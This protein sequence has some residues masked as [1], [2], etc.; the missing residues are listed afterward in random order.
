ML[1]NAGGVRQCSLWSMWKKTRSG[2]YT[3]ISYQDSDC[4]SHDKKSKVV[5]FFGGGSQSGY[6]GRGVGASPRPDRRHL[7]LPR[8]QCSPD[9]T[10]APSRWVP[11]QKKKTLNLLPI[12]LKW[13]KLGQGL[14]LCKFEHPLKIRSEES[15]QRAS[16]TAFV[17]TLKSVSVNFTYTWF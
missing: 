12:S 10:K 13:L 16:S 7:H 17:S 9:Y 3:V 1:D 2:W 14:H 4:F 11:C 15:S 5:K 6:H 8:P